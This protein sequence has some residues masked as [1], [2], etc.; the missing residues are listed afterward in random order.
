MG[1][2]V[3]AVD[4]GSVRPPS[5][6]AWAAF[7]SP[8]RDAVDEG[9]DPQSAVSAL[10]PGLL[11]GA[12]AAL[13][14]EAPMS[15]PVPG[16]QPYRWH[17]LGKAR[18]GE[19]DRPWS[20]G[21]G[22]GALATGLAQGGWMLRQLA[23]TVPELAATTQPGTWRRGD[24]RLLLAEAFITASGKPEPLPAGQHAA[25]AVAA[26]LALMEI[27]DSS[28][29]ITSPVCC[30][31]Q[32]PFNLLAAMALWAGLRIDHAELHAEVLVVAA[33]PEHKLQT[34]RS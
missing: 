28:A 16:G 34:P 23:I 25:D 5:K 15:V 13:V 1:T 30:S 26:G 2:R 7:D 17:E 31:P 19:R 22:A 14:L 27:L 18:R 29:P 9:T 4:I 24:A 21:A 32:D 12:R 10:V 3:V 11:T 20:A 33:Q 8:G 6:F